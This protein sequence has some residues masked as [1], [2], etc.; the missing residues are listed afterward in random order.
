MVPPHI[1]YKSSCLVT[2][3]VNH[4]FDFFFDH[5]RFFVIVETIPLVAILYTE[6]IWDSLT[7]LSLQCDLL[8]TRGDGS[9]VFIDF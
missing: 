2:N 7:S 4:T 5:E 1:A 9:I 8:V 3:D 6:W